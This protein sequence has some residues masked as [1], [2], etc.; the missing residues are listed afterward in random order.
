[1]IVIVA[2]I[3]AVPTTGLVFAWAFVCSRDTAAVERITRDGQRK[4]PPSK[5][6]EVI[7]AGS[8]FA[9]QLAERRRLIFLLGRLL[10]PPI[11]R[12]R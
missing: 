7:E 10:P 6:V 9:F 5:Q 3:A 2:A 4:A 12:H 8:R 1:M 11:Q